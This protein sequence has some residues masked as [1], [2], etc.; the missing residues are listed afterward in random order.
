MRYIISDVVFRNMYIN[1]AKNDGSGG[2]FD[3][4]NRVGWSES[5]VGRMFNKVFSFGSKNIHKILLER[6]KNNL[7]AEYM[8]GVLIALSKQGV[9]VEDVTDSNSLSVDVYIINKISNEKTNIQ[10]NKENK[11]IAKIK[12][13]DFKNYKIVIEKRHDYQVISPEVIENPVDVNKFTVIAGDK[14]ISFDVLLESD[15]SEKP[16]QEQP[17]NKKSD[18]FDEI[19][20]IV[21]KQI[22]LIKKEPKQLSMDTTSTGVSNTNTNIN[23]EIQLKQLEYIKSELEKMN[24]AIPTSDDKIIPDKEYYTKKSQEINEIYNDT[25]NTKHTEALNRLYKFI[26]NRIHPDKYDTSE[27]LN[28]KTIDDMVRLFKGV[29]E[30]SGVTTE[31]F[32]ITS[33]FESFTTIVEDKYSSDNIVNEKYNFNDIINSGAKISPDAKKALDKFGKVKYDEFNIDYVID[34]FNKNKKL[35]NIAVDSVNKEALKEIQLQAEWMYDTNKYGD[36]RS[37]IY[38]RVNWTLTEPDAMQLENIWKVKVA[39]AKKTFSP[40]FSDSNGNFPTSLDPLTLLKSDQAYITNMTKLTKSEYNK[41]SIIGGTPD[42]MMPLSVDESNGL[43]ILT[44]VKNKGINNGEFGMFKITESVSSKHYYLIILKLKNDIQNVH[45]YKILG[46]V[47]NESLL[48]DYNQ[49]SPDAK[50]KEESI[51]ELIKK[52]TFINSTTSVGGFTDTNVQSLNDMFFPEID[53]VDGK[54]KNLSSV[55]YSQNDVISS[56]NMFRTFLKSSVLVNKNDNILYVSTLNEMKAINKTI[57]YS[58]INKTMNT[59]FQLR[60]EDVVKLKQFSNKWKFVTQ[61]SLKN[62]ETVINNNEIIT[63][64]KTLLQTTITGK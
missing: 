8:K 42:R 31:S 27:K 53:G 15:V 48:R 46:I 44:I 2:T 60:I 3:F 35:K 6:L 5:L 29:A 16:V 18:I 37:G 63:K 30:M 26:I 33:I 50:K 51:S 56:S 57:E 40:L 9:A 34:S 38:T 49:L 36:K 41:H 45:C 22:E 59:R 11:Y 13:S 24:K 20:P 28:K 19:L 1:E 61:T 21:D 54:S 32:L 43:D 39:E 10:I 55:L 47:D 62:I 23:N 12:D 58:Q 4:S 25:K 52:Y 17:V 7:Q 64:V 14:K